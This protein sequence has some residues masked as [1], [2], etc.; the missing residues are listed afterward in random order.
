MH[1]TLQKLVQDR[2]Q[3]GSW[4]LI[5]RIYFYSLSLTWHQRGKKKDDEGKETTGQNKQQK[6]T[7]SQKLENG[8]DDTEHGKPKFRYLESSRS[9]R[10]KR[11]CSAESR[12]KGRK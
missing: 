10:S 6:S 1:K 2:K 8:E 4:E 3:R 12:K 5:T 9:A 11:I 7:E